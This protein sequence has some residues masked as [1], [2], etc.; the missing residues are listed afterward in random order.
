MLRPERI[1]VLML[2]M[3]AAVSMLA[4]VPVVMPHHA[5]DA[6]HRALGM[7]D[8]PAMP[9]IVYL[10]RSVSALY[11]FHG[12]LLWLVARDPR[13]YASLI[14]Y[15]GLAFVV[16]GIVS[17]GI[18]IHARLPWFWIAVEGPLLVVIGLA[19]LGLQRRMV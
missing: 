19:I 6:C 17:L 1:L 9:V 8:L 3:I 2:S 10:T 4:A 5:M 14:T 11:V 15:L 16:F 7:G 12:G 18:D 13:R